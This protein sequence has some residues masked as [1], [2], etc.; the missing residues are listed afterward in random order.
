[1]FNLPRGVYVGPAGEIW[2]TDTNNTSDQC[3]GQACAYAAKR[4]G[5][6][7][8]QLLTSPGSTLQIPAAAPSLAVTEDP[9]GDLILADFSNRIAIYFHGL[10]AVNGA[11]Y[12]AT[13]QQQRLAPGMLGSI[14]A[15][16]AIL[17]P[18]SA[19]LDCTSGS[20]TF[21]PPSTPPATYSGF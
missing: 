19:S 14:C 13:Q 8:E 5:N 15:A 11:S 10:R 7:P 20:A 1:N 3:S 2:V 18:G 12:L 17:V 9:N 6:Y 21:A 16:D 4:Y